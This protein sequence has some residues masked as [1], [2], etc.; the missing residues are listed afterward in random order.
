MSSASAL[1]MSFPLAA[2]ECVS[3]EPIGLAAAVAASIAP[4][5]AKIENI[6]LDKA[7]AAKRSFSVVYGG[8]V[9]F[10]KKAF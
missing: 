5:R 10:L 2:R 7:L 3:T 1:V 8:E 9:R 6:M 4:V